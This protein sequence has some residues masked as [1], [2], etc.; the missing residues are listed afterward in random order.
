MK[1]HQS[2]RP[3]LHIIL[4]LLHFCKRHKRNYAFP[5][6]DTIL[7]YLKT[8][9]RLIICRRTLCYHMRALERSGYL[10]RVRRH[11]RS[12]RLGMVFRST[13]YS[14]SRS[15]L[16]LL[17]GKKTSV[18]PRFYGDPSSDRKG[19]VQQSAQYPSTS[20]KDHESKASANAKQAINPD[21]VRKTQGYIGS[22]RD[23][24]RKKTPP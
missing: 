23:A 14:V 18:A 21:N 15:A 11:H 2:S 12:R 13:L 16:R 10:K 24:L 20:I 7:W 19:R 8:T 3:N 6:Q 17:S 22:L 4:A 9:Y 1:T 5:S